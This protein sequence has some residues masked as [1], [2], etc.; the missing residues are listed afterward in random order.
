MTL[1]NHSK[2]AKES[3]VFSLYELPDLVDESTLECC[4]GIANI[5]SIV[6]YQITKVFLN[7]LVKKFKAFAKLLN[8]VTK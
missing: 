8:I 1:T 6:N 2:L 3:R 7:T 4:I 5:T